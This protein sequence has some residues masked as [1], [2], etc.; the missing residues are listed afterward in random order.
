METEAGNKGDALSTIG[1]TVVA[2]V[3][4]LLLDAYVDINLHSLSIRRYGDYGYGTFDVAG[5]LR[6]TL[7]KSTDC[8]PQAL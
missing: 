1:P 7:I 4:K 8:A 6:A 5:S 2:S 3:R